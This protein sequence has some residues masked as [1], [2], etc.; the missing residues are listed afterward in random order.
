MAVSLFFTILL[1]PNNEPNPFESE[2][3]AGARRGRRRL[4]RGVKNYFIV[5]K[6]RKQPPSEERKHQLHG[7]AFLV[8][9]IDFIIS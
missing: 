3:N 8:A 7:A 2:K 4:V 5:P 9:L 6:S 1:P